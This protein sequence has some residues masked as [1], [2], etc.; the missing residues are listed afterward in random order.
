MTDTLAP[1]ADS[2]V[3]PVVVPFTES[4][5]ALADQARLRIPRARKAKRN[6]RLYA[7]LA[8]AIEDLA[9]GVE[10]G[11]RDDRT[12]TVTTWGARPMALPTN[13]PGYTLVE[14]SVGAW[15]PRFPGVSE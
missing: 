9:Q 12:G 1:Q 2:T 3:P 10:Y 13:Y 4:Y 14:R 11:V 7:K 15:T 5:L 6:W 8:Q